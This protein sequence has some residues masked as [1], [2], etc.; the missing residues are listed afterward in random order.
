[1]IEDKMCKYCSKNVQTNNEKDLKIWLLDIRFTMCLNRKLTQFW[2]SSMR[3][4]VFG[5]FSRIPKFFF[6]EK[7]SSLWQNLFVLQIEVPL[8]S[9]QFGIMM[10]K[11]QLLQI[12][13]IFLCVLSSNWCGISRMHWM[14]ISLKK[15]HVS[16]TSSVVYV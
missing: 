5:A 1:M 16:N 11:V 15:S 14:C 8:M 10:I 4:Y 12:L 9:M 2:K 7:N 6:V 3:F 13:R